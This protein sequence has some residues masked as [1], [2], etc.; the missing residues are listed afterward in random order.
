ML[1]CAV[2]FLKR[3]TAVSQDVYK[4]TVAQDSSGDYST[5]HKAIDA[6]RSFPDQRITINV[7]NGTYHEKIIVPAC[8]PR[9]FIMGLKHE[10]KD[11]L[12]YD[13]KFRKCRLL[14]QR[15]LAVENV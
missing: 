14:S 8:N 10:L 15:R 11:S 3:P 5:I 13:V 9:I 2:V 6:S 4:M 7:K 1:I 12:E